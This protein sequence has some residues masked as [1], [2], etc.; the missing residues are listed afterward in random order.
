MEEVVVTGMGLVTSLGDDLDTFWRAIMAGQKGYS[1]P[2]KGAA[3]EGKI[4]PLRADIPA[5]AGAD[6][7]LSGAEQGL[8]RAAQLGLA[9]AASALTDAGLEITADKSHIP[10]VMGTTCGANN[11]IEADGFDQSWFDGQGEELAAETLEN[12]EHSAIATAIARKF[13]LTGPASI[14]GTACAAGNHAVGEAAD[15]IRL[16]RADVVLCGGAE[17]LSLLPIFGFHSIKGLAEEE[18]KPFAH[19]RQGYVIGEGAGV[20]IL[21]SLSHARARGAKIRAR[22]DSWSLNCDA[23]SFALPITD[24][25]RCQ[26]LIEDCLA[27]GGLAPADIDY[28]N[29]HGTG[30]KTTDLME[31][32]GVT[33]ALGSQSKATP[34]SSIKAMTGHTMGAA[35]VLDNI[36]TVLAIENNSIPPIVNLDQ[37]EEGFD[38][39]FITQPEH[40]CQVDR[41]LS[42]SFAF[43]GCNVATLFSAL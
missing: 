3:A 1:L 42:L 11:T 30:S 39:N 12:Y 22:M 32:N 17:S 33:A 15:L 23:S 41:A 40:S 35:G 16:G 8:D 31:V 25:S 21:E 14:I 19:D 4:F 38:L 13:G 43:G 5:F 29:L 27:A 37:P 34:V 24:G 10:V 2:A 36:A 7:G 26:E 18:C 28:V 9:A 20:M 6:H